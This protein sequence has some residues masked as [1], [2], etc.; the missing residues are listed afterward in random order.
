MNSANQQPNNNTNKNKNKTKQTVS[1]ITISKSQNNQTGTDSQSDFSGNETNWQVVTSETNKRPRSP[2]ISN[3]PPMKKNANKFTTENRFS[4]LAP[5][6][7]DAQLS[8]DANSH[9]TENNKTNSSNPPPIFIQT[10]LNFNTFSTEINELTKPTGFECKTSIKG[11]K[12][13]TFN[14]DAYRA[15]VKYLKEKEYA[16][17]SYQNKENKPYRVVIKN[18][19][20]STDT[21]F[22]NDGLASLGFQTRNINNVLH[23]QTK[24]PLPMFFIDL[25]PDNNN[26]EIFKLTSLCYT[27]IKVEA[28]HVRKD[29][30]QC[31]RCQSYGHT[32]SYCNHHPRCVRCGDN[33]DSSQCLKNQK[34]P[35][36][37]ALCG[38]P[39]PANYKGCTV[40]KDLNKIRKQSTANPWHKNTLNFQKPTTSLEPQKSNLSEFPPLQKNSGESFNSTQKEPSPSP[41]ASTTPTCTTDQLASFLNEFKMLINPLISLL[42]SV[43][44]KLIRN[45]DCQ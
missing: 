21:S 29:I 42:T 24:T 14:S 11:L 13:Q 45:N 34:E 26:S 33:H 16:F 40:H 28:P 9:S 22:I 23:R 38:G 4:L 37:C 15:V 25:E 19:H 30:P 7:E 31:L 3:S 5:P 2:K 32:R 41:N 20:L 27:K 6:A 18:L 44:D 43:I 17:H 39:H 8:P 10:E 36:K 12:L 1:P 35:A